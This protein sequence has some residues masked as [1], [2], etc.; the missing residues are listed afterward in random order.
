MEKKIK[1][2]TCKVCKSRFEPFLTTQAT[3]GA[4][5]ALTDA[6]RKALRDSKI[7][8]KSRREAL[9]SLSDHHRDTQA[10]VNRYVRLRDEIAG[11]PCICCDRPF[12]PGEKS[13]AG[14]YLS[15]GGYPEL[16]YDADNNIHRQKVHCNQHLSG[17]QQKYRIG[18]LKRIGLERLAILEG[19]H[20]AKRYRIEDL[21][22]IQRLYQAKIKELKGNL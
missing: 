1:P 13:D 5:C 14:H 17:N 12:R 16:R 18:L 19:P 9:K 10:I 7:R 22:E 6:R 21:K 11:H 15:A 2:K 8:L 3:C 20:E 4:I